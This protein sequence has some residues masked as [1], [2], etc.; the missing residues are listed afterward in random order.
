M[1]YSRNVAYCFRAA[2]VSVSGVGGRVGQHGQRVGAGRRRRRVR[3]EHARDRARDER[4]LTGGQP[5]GV[6]CHE[7][8]LGRIRRVVTRTAEGRRLEAVLR[9]RGRVGDGDDEVGAR[10][11]GT[12]GRP[13]RYSGVRAGLKVVLAP[14][15]AAPVL[16][17][18]AC[19]VSE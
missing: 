19:M 3:F 15:L 8:P 9:G 16:A 10:H 14:S 5:G 7:D 11:L 6:G 18:A 12:V 17:A 1:A 2:G 4:L 13:R